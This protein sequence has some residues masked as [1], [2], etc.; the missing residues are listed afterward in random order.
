MSYEVGECSHKNISERIAKKIAKNLKD[1]GFKTFNPLE[2]FKKKEGHRNTSEYVYGVILD[3]DTNLMVYKNG[4]LYGD[5]RLVI[6]RRL[7]NLWEAK[8]YWD[9]MDIIGIY[10]PK[11]R[12]STGI[13]M[14]NVEPV[15]ENTIR[16]FV[17][18]SERPDVQKINSIFPGVNLELS[19]SSLLGF[20]KY[21][22]QATN[23]D[24][25][26]TINLQN[27][28]N[29]GCLLDYFANNQYV[30]NIS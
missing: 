16:F 24:I 15:N 26:L 25:D 22:F 18:T 30:K 4:F 12:K 2:Y 7:S 21:A 9:H 17:N 3:K 14:Q 11:N 20:Y 29:D 28:T 1:E 5:T 13:G 6:I 8:Y 19:F 27:Y 10:D 23:R